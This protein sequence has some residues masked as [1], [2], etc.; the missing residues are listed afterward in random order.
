MATEHRRQ[1]WL[2]PD[3][4]DL[5]VTMLGVN[6]AT[7]SERGTSNESWMAAARYSRRRIEECIAL[8]KGPAPAAPEQEPGR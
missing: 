2:R 7:L 5:I 4:V 6:V 1:V 8:I 3:Q